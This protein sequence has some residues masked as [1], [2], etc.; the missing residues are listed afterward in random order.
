M[1][2]GGD[3]VIARN[4][5]EDTGTGRARTACGTRAARHATEPGRAPGAWSP[6]ARARRLAWGRRIQP[7]RNDPARRA[8]RDRQGGLLSQRVRPSAVAPGALMPQAA[9]RC[10]AQLGWR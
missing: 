3:L 1:N 8:C 6:A 7:T 2:A 9:G 10:A 5:V 4:H